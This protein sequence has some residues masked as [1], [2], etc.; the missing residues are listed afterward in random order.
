MAAGDAGRVARRCQ[1]CRSGGDAARIGIA[2]R[3]SCRP[4]ARRMTGRWGWPV[5]LFSLKSLAAALLAFYVALSIGLE[6]P[7]WAFLTSYIVAQPLAGA[8]LSK[9]AFRL[10]GT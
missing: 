5:A 6:R 9:A 2:Q 4:T 10:V 7:Y 1:R 8:V 3:P